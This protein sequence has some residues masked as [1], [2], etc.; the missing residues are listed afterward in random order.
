MPRL[1]N[2][3]APTALPPFLSPEQKELLR[4]SAICSKLSDDQFGYFC[5]IVERTRLDPFLGQIRPDIRKSRNDETGQKEPTLL[6]ITT[7]Q[8]LRAT[9]ERTGKLDGESP[10]EWCGINGE[11]HDVWTP[12]EPPAAAKASVY[13]KDRSHPY[14]VV[15][16]WDAFVQLVYGKNGQKIPGP[17]WERMGSHMLGK[18]S[19][20]GA[21]R[22]AF[23]DPCTGLYIHEE[24][25][26]EELNPDS[27]EAIEAEMLRR[28]QAEKE[29]WDDQRKKGILP[30]D[31]QQRLEREKNGHAPAVPKPAPMGLEAP[32]KDP[33]PPSKEPSPPTNRIDAPST[34]WRDFVI[35]RFNLFK[36]RRVDSL[37][38]GELQGMGPIMSKIEEKWASVDEDFK[39]HYNAI[40][41]R[42]EHDQAEELQ[43]LSEGLDFATVNR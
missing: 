33:P 34:D 25:Q 20:A 11:W 16:R 36:G 4:K 43:A 37:T 29:Y 31:E 38:E 15:V 2:P 13:R 8:G 19:L 32:A 9:G 42:I 7:L 10:V 12:E 5:L 1:A 41:S 21:Y 3:P 35:T 39:A 18:C 14:T 27:E 17:F 40:K 26:G 22:A 6:I 24:L 28:A 30:I 23:P